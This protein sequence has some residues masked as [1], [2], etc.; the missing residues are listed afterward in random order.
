MTLDRAA[1]ARL[2]P[3]RDRM[4]LLEEVLAWDEAHAL[5][6]ATSHRAADNPLRAHGRLGVACGIEYAGQ[7]MALHGALNAPGR[8]SPQVGYLTSL[9]D[10]VFQ[11][12]RLDDVAAD[13]E[14]EVRRHA[15]DGSHVVYAFAVRAGGRELLRGRAA[16]VLDVGQR[17]AAAGEVGR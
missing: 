12:D 7:A 9:R 15:G 1:I 6:R 2:I 8:A 14:I 4:C 11:A 10:V 17:G 16:V 13:L 5:C 3:H